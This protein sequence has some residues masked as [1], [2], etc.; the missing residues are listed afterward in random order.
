[1]A[2]GSQ[3]FEINFSKNDGLI[4]SPSELIS[5]CLL[6]VPLHFEGKEI[7]H[8]QI[9]QYIAATQAEVEKS[10]N[11]K[12]TKQIIEE[13]KS[14]YLDDFFQWGFL[15]T[16][17]PV[18]KAFKLQGFVGQVKQIDYPAEW[19]Q[20]K[21]DST[22]ELYH[23]KMYLVPGQGQ[24]TSNNV[25]LSGLFPQAGFLGNSN[26]PNYWTIRYCTGFQKPP[27]DLVMFVANL[28]SFNIFNI[29]G[30]LIL[31]AGIASQSIGIDGL[32]Q[33]I[34]STASAENTAFGG[35]IHA[36]RECLK[37]S[38]E[39]MENYYKGFAMGVM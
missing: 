36:V 4:L 17:F 10:W 27:Q 7:S 3:T 19:I 23:R 29:M 22:G 39:R 1:M 20:T 30:D 32:S 31:G 8:Q 28:A 13:S 14:F 16:T 25:V 24:A 38:L 5:Q 26:I 2:A 11:L 34:N 15:P 6:G 33:S 12:M 35:R 21:K 9:A 37:E 18:V